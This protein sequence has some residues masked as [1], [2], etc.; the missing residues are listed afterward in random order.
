MEQILIFM[1]TDHYRKFVYVLITQINYAYLLDDINLRG[2]RMLV[3]FSLN[4]LL[5]TFGLKPIF[6]SNR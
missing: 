6:F 2:V 3:S 4:I 1:I 5:I